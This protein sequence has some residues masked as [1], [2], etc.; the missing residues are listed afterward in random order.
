M[1][2][3]VKSDVYNI[4]GRIKKFDPS[5]RIVYNTVPNRY[6]IYSTHLQ[7][8]VD[9]ISG[10]PLSYV[11]CIPYS[12]LDER[13]IEHLYATRVENIYEIVEAID[14]QN[15]KIEYENQQKL[16]NKSLI[17][18]ENKLRQLT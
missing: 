10:I 14:K 1:K 6:E 7:N 11:C 15:Q 4:C 12:E 9:L 5:Y 13:A 18:A 8:D 16:K 17:I 3:L 2:I